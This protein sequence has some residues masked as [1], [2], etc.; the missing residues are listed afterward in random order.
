MI[1][2]LHRSEAKTW[3]GK[4]HKNMLNNHCKEQKFKEL[5]EPYQKGAWEPPKPAT[6]NNGIGKGEMRNKG[7]QAHGPLSWV[8]I[9]T[10][11]AKTTP[12]ELKKEKVSKPLTKLG[13]S[14]GLEKSCTYEYP[15]ANG[16]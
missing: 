9:A 2:K 10:T 16:M 15:S 7:T 6:A 4:N 14:I 3:G 5:K 12:I 8:A 1:S 11:Y 13:K